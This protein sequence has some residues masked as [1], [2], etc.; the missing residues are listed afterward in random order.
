MG[1]VAM[2]TWT[3]RYAVEA[4]TP[5]MWVGTPTYYILRLVEQ[6]IVFAIPAFL[7]ITGYSVAMM[8]GRN[9]A[10]VSWKLVFSRIKTL[11]IPYLLWSAVMIVLRLV[12]DPRVA[13]TEILSWVLTG[14][15][16]EVLYFVPLLT[17]FYLLSP[18]LVRWAR[19]DWKSLLMLTVFLQLLVQLLA[20]PELLGWNLPIARD[21]SQFVP[22]WLFLARIFW[23][24]FGIICGLHPV[25]FKRIVSPHKAKL[26]TAAIM[27]IPINFIEWE[28]YYKI[29]GQTW[30][31][32]RETIL[33]SLYTFAL[34]LSV[35]ML[36][37]QSLP[38][39]NWISE[40]GAKSYG[41]YLTHSL[42]IVYLARLIYHFL[43]GL[44]GYPLLLQPILI[45]AGLF[46][47]LGMMAVVDRSRLRRFYNYLYG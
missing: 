7:F 20:Y 12:E 18:W 30:L 36:N 25:E 15:S 35:L 19:R 34:I 9:Q 21:I 14:S 2:F 4:M 44:L 27:L 37:G 5:E 39:S 8:T 43:P 1:F 46:I 11:V 32:H 13:L 28:I 22:K 26:V 24:P 41:I 17:Q 29:A 38:L 10:T 33:D 40:L 31:S 16:N 45:V 47:P 23:F 6:I 3:H 42:A